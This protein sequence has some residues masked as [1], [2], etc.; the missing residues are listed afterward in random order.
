MEV[1]VLC[2]RYGSLSWLQRQTH[3]GTSF[4]SSCGQVAMARAVVSDMIECN[5]A[6]KKAND[7]SDFTICFR[8]GMIDW[9]TM[10][11]LL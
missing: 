2:G 6:I 11:P 5:K 9:E 1:S 8:A 7:R 3:P 10:E 4:D